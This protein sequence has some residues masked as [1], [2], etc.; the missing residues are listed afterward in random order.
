MLA[1]M[2]FL[3][4]ILLIL[5]ATSLTYSQTAR[6]YEKAGDQ[7]FQNKDLGA[8]LQYFAEAIALKPN[9]PELAY[10]YAEVARSFFAYELALVYY[11][12][13]AESAV[14]QKFPLTLFWIGEV[15]RGKGEYKAAKM[16]YE[17]FLENATN[18]VFKKEARQRTEECEW[19]LEVINTPH[20]LKIQALN[21]RVNT[22]YSEFGP[23]LR[24]DTLYYSSLR[25]DKASDDNDPPRKISKVL[26]SVKGSKGRPMRQRFNTDDQLTAHSAFSAS[27]D[28]I[29]FTICNYQ[30]GLKIRCDL[31]YRDWNSKRRRWGTAEKLPELINSPGTTTTHPNLF[32]DQGNKKSTMFFTSDRLGGKGGLDI[33]MVNLKEDGTFSEPKNLSALNTEKDE[34]TPFLHAPTNTLFFSSNGYLGLG[35]FDIYQSKFENG[36]LG[37]VKHTG[38][39]MNSSFN[40]MYFVL[41][42]DSTT[43]Y[44]S[45]NREGAMYLDEN[46]KSCCND[47]F[48]AQISKPVEPTNLPKDSSELV[49]IPEIPKTLDSLVSPDPLVDIDLPPT[50]LEDFLPLALYFDNDEPDRRTRRNTTKK[51]YLQTFDPYVNRKNEF[52]IAYAEGFEGESR[53]RAEESIDAFFEEKV[54]RGQ[55]YLGLFSDILL[56]RLQE[57]EKIEI[58]IKGFTSPRAKSDYNIHLGKRRI[59]SVKN[60]FK[61]Y[62]SGIFLPYINKGKLVLS[63]RSFGET[64]ARQNVNDDLNNQRLS[65]FSPEASLERRVEIVEIVR[66]EQ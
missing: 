41:D 51:S 5:F 36:L 21:K 60:H 32:V 7:A 24:G 53:I 11:K 59:S 62:K 50:T 2:R 13:V 23:F 35:G 20:N 1:N 40:D 4:C 63:E 65:I 34:I 27:G 54:L 29:Y 45:S 14:A 3:C 9:D 18:E 28:R 25:Y 44:L 16:A 22:P 31:Y 37:E 39:P 30:E 46:N 48:R 61:T 6:A 10:K 57:G 42:T 43:A 17:Q 66:S 64:T 49:G 15:H 55:E 12:K 38:Y 33:W 58:F 56:K 19:A 8:A 52:K 26:T 47:I